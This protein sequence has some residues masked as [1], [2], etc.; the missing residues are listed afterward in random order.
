[1]ARFRHLGCGSGILHVA[2]LAVAASAHGA[3]G[4]WQPQQLPAIEETLRSAGIAVDPRE[5]SDPQRYPLNAVVELGD[6]CTAALVSPLGLLLGSRHCVL[7]VLRSQ[8]TEGR[9]LLADGVVARTLGEELP[10]APA[11]RVTQSVQDVTAQ[12]R[13]GL[14]SGQD[15]SARAQAIESRSRR[16]LDACESSPGYRCRIDAPGGGDQYFLVRQLVIR[17]VRLAYVPAA[18]V[19]EFGGAGDSASWPRQRADFA[20][21]RAYVG[22]DGKPADFSEVN[23]PLRPASHLKLQVGL[24]SGDFALA[25]GY[26][27]RSDDAD[28]SLRVSFG[29]VRGTTVGGAELPAFSDVEGLRARHTG[30]PPFDAGARVI[31]AIDDRRFGRYAGSGSLPVNFLVDF[32]VARGSS[33]SPVLNA[34]AGLIGVASADSLGRIDA[35]R[36][37]GPAQAHGIAVDIRFVL[38][39]LEAVDAADRLLQELVVE[40]AAPDAG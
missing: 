33:G 11:V 25:L 3:P 40:P 18:G 2:L 29:R 8:S 23:V 34:R 20:L 27:A 7:E 1:M 31:A 10:G 22:P 24:A 32:D 5:L 21:L 4:L 17:D 39:L 14:P 36:S 12:V 19:G 13:A 9:D 6:D 37:S 35:E 15:G 30:T 38:W 28:G 16:L 26:P